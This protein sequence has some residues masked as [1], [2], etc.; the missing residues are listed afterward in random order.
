MLEPARRPFRGRASRPPAGRPGFL[1][2]S[3]EGRVRPSVRLALEPI[4]CPIADPCCRDRAAQRAGA[5]PRHRFSSQSTSRTVGPF[6][7]RPDSDTCRESHSPREVFLVIRRSWR[8]QLKASTTQE[9][10]LTVVSQFLEEWSPGE[11]AALPR[12]ARPGRLISKSDV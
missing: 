8:T 2:L 10:V 12:E 1:A 9:A 3:P 6:A 11:I 5:L 7:P 4:A